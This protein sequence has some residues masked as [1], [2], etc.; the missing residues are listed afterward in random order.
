MLT[1]SVGW[2]IRD[3]K[4]GPRH[5]EAGPQH[6]RAPTKIIQQVTQIHGLNQPEWLAGVWATCGTEGYAL[7][8]G[9]PS[10]TL[11]RQSGR[12][13]TSKHVWRVVSVS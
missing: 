3:Y 9:L 10:N 13:S 4:H 5:E 1:T 11:P 7:S 6:K 2:P 8:D 12:Q